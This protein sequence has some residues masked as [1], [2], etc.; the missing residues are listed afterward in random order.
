METGCRIDIEKGSGL[1]T[2]KGTV[3]AVRGG[4]AAVRRQIEDGDG[5]GGG[6]KRKRDSEDEP[7]DSAAYGRELAR[8]ETR[9]TSLNRRRLSR[10]LASPARS[11]RRQTP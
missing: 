2:I 4:A 3:A 8:N 10:T 5:G 6:F 7:I 1:C 11:P 9:M